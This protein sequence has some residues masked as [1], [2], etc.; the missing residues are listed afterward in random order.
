[1]KQSQ[2]ITVQNHRP[3]MHSIQN[4]TEGRPTLTISM[5][6]QAPRASA[7]AFAGAAVLFELAEEYGVFDYLREAPLMDAA[8]MAAASGFSPVLM[9][10]YL[11]ALTTAGLV[12]TAA[13]EDG[14]GMTSL[15][16]RSPIFN[17]M[18]NGT[19]YLSWSLR[20]C[21]PLIDHAREYA[22]DWERAANLY[23][24]NGKLV[25]RTSRWIGERSFYPQS[26][27]AILALQPARIIDL[28]AGSAGLLIRC[29]SQ[30]PEDTTGTAV[31][32]SPAACEHA[33]EEIALA[34]LS[35]R[36]SVICAPVQDVDAYRAQLE[37]ADLVHAGF[38][39]HD[40]LHEHPEG[41]HEVLRAARHATFLLVEAVPYVASDREKE[42]SA[43]FS[44]LHEAFMGLDLQTEAQW[45]GH[46]AGAGYEAVKIEP[47]GMPGARLIVARAAGQA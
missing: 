38:V 33:R 42:F 2:S 6:F 29:L 43:A 19:G 45:R 35:D 39:L 44:F 21:G 40:V 23:P 36:I 7:S 1:M 41:F 27:Q 12:E 5:D 26:E 28:G 8:S 13:T 14:A 25:A 31:D 46:F 47:L 3:H 9:E 34:G 18:V 37:A 15:Y 20:A 30:M 11:R 16:R 10:R 4:S 22:A 24:R 17:D 32:I